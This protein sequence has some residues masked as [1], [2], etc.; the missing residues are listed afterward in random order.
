MDIDRDS[1]LWIHWFVLPISPAAH[2][3]KSNDTLTEAWCNCVNFHSKS[4]KLNFWKTPKSSINQMVK[5]SK[6]L[7]N[8]LTKWV[9]VT[10][11]HRIKVTEMGG[12]LHECILHQI[13]F[14]PRIYMPIL[15]PKLQKITKH[16]QCGYKTKTKLKHR[17]HYA[18]FQNCRI[19]ASC[20][21]I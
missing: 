3:S 16:F 2:A 17:T 10:K 21:I 18:I 5:C 12:I 20:Q 7:I 4:D 14:F 15:P 6:K 8:Q 19:C 1:R 9:N 11:S 13:L